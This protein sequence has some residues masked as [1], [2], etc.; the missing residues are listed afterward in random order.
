MTTIYEV[1]LLTTNNEITLLKEFTDLDASEDYY[2]EL[3]ALNNGLPVR[4]VKK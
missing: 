1:Y 3:T 2:E 4:R